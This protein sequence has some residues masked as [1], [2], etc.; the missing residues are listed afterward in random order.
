MKAT[1]EELRFLN[2]VIQLKNDAIENGREI[3]E[4]ADKI[5]GI[6][7]RANKLERNLRTWISE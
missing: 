5:K 3:R 4:I 7:R 6:T 1:K 2:E